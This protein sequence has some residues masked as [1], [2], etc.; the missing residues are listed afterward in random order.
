MRGGLRF[1]GLLALAAT[2]V[3]IV[4]VKAVHEGWFAYRPAL[5]LQGDPALLYFTL[6]R[7]CECQMRVIRGADAQI[8]GWTEADRSGLPVV[9]VDLIQRRDLGER[10]GVYRAPALLLVDAD[11]RVIWRQDVGVSDE[12][13]LDL[14]QAQ[15]QIEALISED[16]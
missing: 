2:V 4:G 11:E 3:W 8:A 6:S 14:S 12:A 7:G 15:S 13:P 1:W 5:D 9:R 10:F 16:A